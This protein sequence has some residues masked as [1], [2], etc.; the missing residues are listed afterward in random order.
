[1]FGECYPYV[2]STYGREDGWKIG[3]QPRVAVVT[4]GQAPRPDVMGE[5]RTILGD[6]SYT[7]FGV[8]DEVSRGA[9]RPHG[10]LARRRAPLHRR[11]CATARTSFSKPMPSTRIEALVERIDDQRFDLLILAM[12][13][14]RYPAGDA[15]AADPRPVRGRSLGGRAATTGNSR[16]GTIFPLAGQGHPAERAGLRHR[17]C[18]AR[19]PPSAAASAPTLDPRDRPRRLRRPD[20]DEFGRLH[21]EMAQQVARRAASR[22]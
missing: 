15:H 20:R 11:S 16:I 22:W 9:D 14:I 3:A 1:M 8:L 2:L 4:M 6:L 19:T 5:L 17:Y 10:R 12:T 7:E 13:G 18:K 21:E